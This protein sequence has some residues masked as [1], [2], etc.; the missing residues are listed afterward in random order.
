[1]KLRLRTPPFRLYSTPSFRTQLFRF[2]RIARPEFRRVAA[3]IALLFVSSSVSMAVPFSMGTIIDMVMEDKARGGGGAKGTLNDQEAQQVDSL[4]LEGRADF[5]NQSLD[6]DGPKNHSYSVINSKEIASSTT[7]NSKNTSNNDNSTSTTLIPGL[8]PSFRDKIKQ[9]GSLDKL[10]TVLILVFVTGAIANMGRNILM[11]TASERIITRLR[12]QLY[13]R[14]LT[15]DISFHDKSRSGELISRLATDT[16][17]V[18]K[19]L[20]NNVS[21][22]LRALVYIY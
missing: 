21:D 5:K 4:A 1:M 9:I 14:L 10:F 20:T 17:V 3:A 11:K 8:S 18:S 7:S 15:Q 13:K 19:S 6:L 16:V 22:G 2:A 12:N